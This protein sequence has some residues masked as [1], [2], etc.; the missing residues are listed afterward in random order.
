MGLR[1]I[2]YWLGTFIFDLIIFFFN[3]ALFFVVSGI[4]DLNIVFDNW[5]RATLC[6]IVFGPSQILFA[7]VMGFVFNKLENALKLFTI[8]CFFIMF[9]FPNIL[10]AFTAFFYKELDKPEV[11]KYIIYVMEV[12][13]SVNIIII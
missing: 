11:L 3:L 4:L 10:V 6:F 5:W 7:Y 2:A 8:F 1:N 12:L 9:C 13:F